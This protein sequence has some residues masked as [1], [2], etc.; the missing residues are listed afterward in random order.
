MSNDPFAGPAA[1]RSFQSFLT[2][3][4]AEFRNGRGPLETAL[5]DLLL[6]WDIRPGPH[7][8][9]DLLL[10]AGTALRN[11]GLGDEV[12]RLYD[13]R[14]NE[15]LLPHGR[16]V[17]LALLNA[18]TDADEKTVA[19]LLARLHDEY[20]E[21]MLS[22]RETLEFTAY[23]MLCAWCYY[24]ARD[25]RVRLRDEVKRLRIEM[26]IIRRH[27]SKENPQSDPVAAK[28]LDV[29]LDDDTEFILDWLNPPA[30]L[31][32]ADDLDAVNNVVAEMTKGATTGAGNPPPAGGKKRRIQKQERERLVSDYLLTNAKS[33]PT[34]QEVVSATGVSAGAICTTPAWIEYN[35]SRKA[36]RETTATIRT[37]PD[38][39]QALVFIADSKAEDPSDVAANAEAENEERET[40]ERLLAFAK[41]DQERA[42]F[43]AMEHYDRVILLAAYDDI[44]LDEADCTLNPKRRERSRRS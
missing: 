10:A 4:A 14:R 8:L 7:A 17:A 18:A 23:E 44:G 31:N 39:T 6:A 21:L 29:L 11:A 30:D 16:K 43:R 2:T 32:D 34:I 40:L 12:R 24:H 25:Y 38:G 41:N 20:P 42:R 36:K 1:Y 3:L 33:D 28:L 35:A 5:A 13:F 37:I 27:W 22:A 9:T 26:V 19:D 15:I